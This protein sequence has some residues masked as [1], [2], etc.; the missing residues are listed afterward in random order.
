MLHLF[1]F[2]LLF[3]EETFFVILFKE[4][5]KIGDPKPVLKN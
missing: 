4:L 2:I 5:H 3:T 1:W